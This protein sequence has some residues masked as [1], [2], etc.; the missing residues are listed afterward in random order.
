MEEQIKYLE[1]HSKEAGN[2][3]VDIK[4]YAGEGSFAK[5]ATSEE[6]FREA[7]HVNELYSQKKYISRPDVF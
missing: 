2:G 1:W 3:L 4:F 6:F 7:N 5:N